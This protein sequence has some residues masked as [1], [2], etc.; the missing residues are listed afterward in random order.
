VND[1]L[2]QIARPRL[3]GSTGAQEVADLVHERLIRLGY[4]V[5]DHPFTFST[6]PGRFAITAAGVV[7]LSGTLG[8]AALLN[9]RHPGVALVILLLTLLLCAAIAVLTAPLADM[10]P[11]GRITANNMFAARPNAVPRYIFMAHLDS[12]SQPIPLAFRGPAIILAILAWLA[13]VVFALLGLLDP[14][15]IR[16]DITT[17]LGVIA[18]LAAVLLVFCWVENRSPGALDNAS[19]VAAVLALAESEKDRDD[20]AF[21]ITDAEELG[22]VGARSIARKL[23]PVFGVI[24]IDGIDDRGPLYVLEKFGV[25]P[26]YIAPHLVASIL[27]AAE[28][29]NMPAQR[30]N[31]PFGLLLD[32]LPMAKADLPAVTVMRGSFA[33]LRRV[34]RPTD[35]LQN[36]TGSGIDGVV[37]VLRDALVLLRQEA[38]MLVGNRAAR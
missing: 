26:R 20:V 4:Q 37:R 25:P 1:L 5:Q 33:S 2:Q 34:H 17:V 12:K 7:F 23:N 31:V 24:N 29:L 8:A 21:L 38:A 13:L 11:F 35:N 27:Q 16:S 30:R 18:F 22:L 14:V 15:W 19:G 36:M 3:T 6:W 10:F 28:A 32:H 9:M